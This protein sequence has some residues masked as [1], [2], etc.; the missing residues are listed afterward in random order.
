MRIVAGRA[1]AV[2]EA[3]HVGFAGPVELGQAALRV[4]RIGFLQVRHLVPVE[5]A[6]I[7]APADDLADEALDA[8]ERRAPLA[9]GFLR[10]AAQL[11][12]VEQ[13]EIDAGR[14]HRM[15]QIVL[16]R[17]HRVLIGAETFYPLGEKGIGGLSGLLARDGPAELPER[18]EMVGEPSLDQLDDLLR[19]GIGFELGPFG[20]GQPLLGRLAVLAV[21]IPRAAFGLAVLGH[22]Q[23]GLAPHLAVE[24]LHPEFLAVLRPVVEFGLAADEA[25]VA[26]DFYFAGE[27]VRPLLH[28]LPHAPLACLDNADE[29]RLVPFDRAR[30]LAGEAAGIVRIAKFGVVD[31][32][33]RIAQFLGEMAHGGKDQRDLLLVVADIGRL[34]PHL[35]HQDDAIVL[36]APAQ[37]GK[38][39]GQLVAEDG[40]K[41]GA[42]H[43]CS[44]ARPLRWCLTAWRFPAS[45]HSCPVRWPRD[46]SPPSRRGRNADRP[47][48]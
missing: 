18:A 21:V 45:P 24:E 35:H 48:R 28:V 41:D 43:G 46:R 10:A 23:P 29:T 5:A 9:I 16:A 47:P 27:L 14:E 7:F 6:D 42:G 8:V 12:R 19:Y 4:E 44:N 3:G 2:G 39:A 30:D 26:Q 25:V 20:G 38:V 31:A 33:S 15:E 37:A 40:H 34:V 32:P 1:D 22:E 11:E 17:D 13:A 36:G